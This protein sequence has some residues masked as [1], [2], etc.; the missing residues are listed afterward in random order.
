MLGF[1]VI[2]LYVPM[3]AMK[4]THLSAIFA[5]GI[6]LCAGSPAQQ[7]QAAKPAPKASAPASQ[8]SESKTEKSSAPSC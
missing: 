4:I 3:L 1:T 8:K 6:A 2:L 7:K 5:I